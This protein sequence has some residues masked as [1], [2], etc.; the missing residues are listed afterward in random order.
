MANTKVVLT[1]RVKTGHGW[2]HYPAAYAANGKVNAGVVIVAGQEAMH[3]TG[4]YELRF[5]EG[6]KSE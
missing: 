1:M 3:K 4:Y 6:D 5:Y 2:S